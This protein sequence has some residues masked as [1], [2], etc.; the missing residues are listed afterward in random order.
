MAAL[1]C[2]VATAAVVHES[3]TVFAAGWTTALLR[4]RLND[5][6]Q[7]RQAWTQEDWNAAEQTLTQAIQLTPQ[8]TVVL[9]QLTQLY[10]IRGRKEWTGGEAGSP[11]VGWYVRA[12]EVQQ[13]SIDLRPL[14]A[15]AWA[16]L[17]VSQSAAGLPLDKVFATWRRAN[18]LGPLEPEVRTTLQALVLRHWSDAPVD[19]IA[20]MEQRE[21]GV[22]A[23]LVR[24]E[25]VRQQQQLEATEA[26]AAAEAASVAAAV[27][28]AAISAAAARAKAAGY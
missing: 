19:A 18:Q 23:R 13:R 2:T 28:R 21:P 20:W 27:R 26:I 16:N 25:K 17:A 24:E 4:E 1:I 6:A 12:A 3:S 22:S 8:D 14:N 11:E 9:D 5:W 7:E 10:S 15:I